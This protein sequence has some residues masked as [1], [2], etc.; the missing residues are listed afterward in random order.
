M[1]TFFPSTQTSRVVTTSNGE[2]AVE[3]V[4]RFYANHNLQEESPCSDISS[5]A[6]STCSPNGNTCNLVQKQIERLY[7]GKVLPVR[8]TSPG[9]FQTILQ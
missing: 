5:P 6:G 9:A 1:P 8:L 2:T 4:T 3:T 7:G